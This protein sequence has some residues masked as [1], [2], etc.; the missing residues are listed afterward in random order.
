MRTETGRVRIVFDSVGS[1]LTVATKT[2]REPI[3]ADPRGKLQGFAIAGEDRKWVWA[4]AVIDGETVLVSS[5][6]VPKPLA[7]RYAFTMNPA[8][9]NLYNKDGLPASPFRTDD[10]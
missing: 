6:A 2:G 7:V 5:P 1:G 3:V 8:S 4:D 9:A 10:W